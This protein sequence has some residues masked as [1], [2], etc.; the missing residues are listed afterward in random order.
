VTL[1]DILGMDDK[2]ALFF[3]VDA[4]IASL[5]MIAGLILITSSYISEQPRSLINHMSQDLLNVLAEQKVHEAN[6]SFIQDLVNNGSITDVNNSILVQLGEFWAGNQLVLANQFIS[7]VSQGILDEIFGYSIAIDNE[8][9][10][11]EATP[12]KNSLVSSKKIISGIQKS[13]PVKGFV[14]KARATSVQKITNQIVSFSPEG[15]GWDGSSTSKAYG[16][17]TK[18]FN[19]TPGIK[20]NNATLYLSFHIEDGGSD[21]TVVN[22]NNGTCNITRNSLGMTEEGYFGSRNVTACLK[23]GSNNFF[24]TLW[25]DDYNAHLHPGMY[26]AINYNTTEDVSYIASE[27]R[28]RIYFDNIRSVEANNDGSGVWALMP[29]HVPAGATNVSA[30]LRLNLQDVNDL[31]DR[32]LVG[33]S[34]Q[35]RDA[36]DFRIYVNSDTVFYQRNAT[37]YDDID[38]CLSYSAACGSNYNWTGSFNITGAVVTGTNI[39]SVYVNNYGDTVGGDGVTSIYSNPVSDPANS[40]YLELNY[41]LTPSLP[42]SV[43]EIRQ[44]KSFGGTPNPTK[45]VNFSFPPEAVAISSVYTHIAEQYSYI[46]RVYGDDAYVPA[47]LVFESPAPRAVP[48]DV[49]I[50]NNFLDVSELA[51]NYI[52]IAETS[53]NDVRQESS[54][55]YGFYLPSSVGYGQVFATLSEANADAISRLQSVM[56]SFVNVSTVELDNTSMSDVPSLWGPAVIEVRVWN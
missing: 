46:T 24:V 7:N 54:V 51:R 2:K 4:L 14:A 48:T 30:T 16:Y 21:W 26:L 55:D 29:F 23:N 25:N 28:E 8:T 42:Y 53:G 49:V 43:V 31:K 27:H 32:Y 6:N 50:P 11:S 45:N 9:I 34:Y 39:V 18:W 56:G 13:K 3:T 38:D 5:I 41:S 1:K 52:R 10:F 37:S 15:S 36:W 40:S 33:W 22:I 12:V 19:I 35:Y 47:N 44:L 17:I 20:I